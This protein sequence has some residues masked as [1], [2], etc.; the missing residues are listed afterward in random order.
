MKRVKKAAPSRNDQVVRVLQML[1]ELERMGGVD[2]YELAQKY[3]G[4]TRTIRRDLDALRESGIPLT[5]TLSEDS[6]KKRWTVDADA[7]KSL[8]RLIDAGHYLALR[9]AMGQGGPVRDQ[10]SIFAALED[11]A[12]RIETAIGQAGRARLTA[13]DACFFSWE[14]FAWTKAAPE[15]LWPL[16]E[17]IGA[18]FVPVTHRLKVVAD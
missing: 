16:V 15:F 4:S 5:E 6:Q 2:L 18:A 7:L 8:T 12:S 11:V 3:G 1:R 13:I 17:A 10:S 9:V 14:K